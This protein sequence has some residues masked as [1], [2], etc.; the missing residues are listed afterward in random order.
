[1]ADPYIL[2]PGP[3]SG[4][5][6][7]PFYTHA[8][9][10][11][12]SPPGAVSSLHKPQPIVKR[13][14]A[15]ANPLKDCPLIASSQKTTTV[16]SMSMEAPLVSKF[17]TRLGFSSAP[18]P[19]DPP[20]KDHEFSAAFFA[21]ELCK[22]IIAALKVTD[23]GNTET[24]IWFLHVSQDDY[25]HV[26]ST[27]AETE[28]LIHKPA[29]IPDLKCFIAYKLPS[30]THNSF[31]PPMT[32][33]IECAIESMP[34]NALWDLIFPIHMSLL[35]IV[36]AKKLG[37]PDLLFEMDGPGGSIP[38][39]IMEVS[40][41]WAKDEVMSSVCHYAMECKDVQEWKVVSDDPAFG[42]VMSSVPHQWASP[43]TIKV[44][45]WLCQSDGEFSLDEMNSS[46][47]YVWA[48]IC[49]TRDSAEITH[50]DSV[51]HQ[52]MKL[53]CN[54]ITGYVQEHCEFDEENLSAMREWIPPDPLFNWDKV[55]NH[56][57]KGVL[58][59]GFDWYCDWHVNLKCQADELA[60][61]FPQEE[62]SKWPKR[63]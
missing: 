13:H 22:Q 37:M 28:E 60:E 47:Y 45:T 38:L 24:D 61:Q 56:I 12:S 8:A 42:P 43:L 54:K 27:I 57:C 44:K 17:E 26:M 41:S 10:V 19:S 5:G 34:I 14:S 16:V 40:F 58:Y 63:G 2:K 18:S 7:L 1:M 52:A 62:P 21:T 23:G 4:P 49:P 33:V 36:M 20:T 29:Y 3:Q 11:W 55:M 59:D 32:R 25:D 48:E 46:S 51:F 9:H 35:L 6:K 15:P 31:L 53:I 50:L 30:C 39:W